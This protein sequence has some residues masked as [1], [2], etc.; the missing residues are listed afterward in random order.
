MQSAWT[1]GR[2]AAA[3]LVTLA[4]VS[5]ATQAQ[6]GPPNWQLDRLGFFDAVHTRADGT[7]ISQFVS[8]SPQGRVTGTSIRYLG[9]VEQGLSA[10]TWTRATGNQRIGFFDLE[11]TQPG[12]FQVSRAFGANAVGQVI[13]SSQRFD[14]A[15][16]GSNGNTTWLWTP[17]TGV[18]RIGLF[19]AEHTS[20]NAGFRESF[21][22]GLNDS[23]QAIGSSTRYNAEGNS[24]GATA[25]VRQSDGSHTRLGFVDAIHTDTN[26]DRVSRVRSLTQSGLVTGFSQ[27]FTLPDT[28]QSL[29]NW[30]WSQAEGTV[31]VDLTDSLHVSPQGRRA[32][33]IVSVTESG[34]VAGI[35]QRLGQPA[36]GV[37]AWTWTRQSG[38]TAIGLTDAQHTGSSG[39][40]SSSIRGMNQN[41][42]IM[43]YAQRFD[44]AGNGFPGN[45]SAWTWA[46]SGNTIQIG[47]TDAE[48]TSPDNV[49][50]NEPLFLSEGG[51]IAGSAR[52][53][54]SG[55]EF[56]RSAWAWSEATS[57]RKVGIVDPAHTRANGQRWSDA[58]GV[59]AAGGVIGFSVRFAGQEFRGQ[60]GWFHDLPT[61]TTIP[62]VFSVASN[63]ARFT[64][65]TLITDSGWVLGNYGVYSG[66][67]L[68]SDN[69]FVWS[70]SRGFTS[71][72]ALVDG[73]LGPA[74]WS[75]LNSV[76]GANEFETIVGFGSI[77]G[78]TSETRAIFA[79]TVP[80]P[81]AGV[82]LLT[83]GLLGAAR[84]RRAT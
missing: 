13:G 27:R 8:L 25:W 65:P 1:N 75:R 18:E 17:T 62:L 67:T 51:H 64:N 66:N 6:W 81:S 21:V 34:R 55:N 37:T 69:A 71:L 41:G 61:N 58:T 38:H 77:F 32:T 52:R 19:D 78:S 12:G 5:T 14:Q 82:C 54:V 3:V 73:G 22:V 72:G 44:A 42:R 76:V 29:T 7:Q 70:L 63:G 36:T 60:S 43:G 40:Q 10:W 4:G 59:N 57:T 11:H 74:G 48:H 35:S 68:V 30:I 50:S 53:Y 31:E 84:R 15:T 16:N 79:L 80:S 23:G 33:E 9:T 45:Q 56:D 49:Q 28:G 26:G 46:P 2:T 24:T 83:V 47:L 20:V 39:L